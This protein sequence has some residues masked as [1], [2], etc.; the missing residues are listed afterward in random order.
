MSKNKA[1]YFAIY[2]QGHPSI[3]EQN[4]QS[5]IIL[6]DNE[7]EVRKAKLFCREGEILFTIPYEKIA[8]ANVG[9]E[10]VTNTAAI[11]GLG[12]VGAA[13]AGKKKNE[14]IEI[15]VKGKDRDGKDVN[16]MILF[17]KV[18]TYGAV[19]SPGGL[20]LKGKLDQEIVKINGITI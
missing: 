17:D 8:S 6:R 14:Q 4:I 9:N 18:V 20:E 12:L 16:V 13:L 10:M 1:K 2:K 7:L 15:N 11:V 3:K 19:N 5:Y